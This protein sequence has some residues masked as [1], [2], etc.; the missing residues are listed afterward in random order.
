[1]FGIADLDPRLDLPLIKEQG[2]IF[3]KLFVN[4]PLA[5]WKRK[6]KL[7]YKQNAIVQLYPTSKGTWTIYVSYRDPSHRWGV[8]TR[9]WTGI[10]SESEFQDAFYDARIFVSQE[11]TRLTGG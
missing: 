7:W 3:T 10:T 9:T 8:R 1:M 4:M 11:I 5:W 2:T 6:T